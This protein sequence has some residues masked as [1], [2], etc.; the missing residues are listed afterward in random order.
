MIVYESSKQLFVE[1]VV[2]GK[3]EKNIDMNN[4]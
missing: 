2:Q 3:I 4:K 1:N